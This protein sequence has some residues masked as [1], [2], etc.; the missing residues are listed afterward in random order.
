MLLL[1]L[2][3]LFRLGSASATV[4]PVY[5]TPDSSEVLAALTAVSLSYG[6][7]FA[8]A[9]SSGFLNAYTPD[10][11]ILAAGSPALCSARGR[12][13]FYKFAYK[14]GIRNVV[15]HTVALYGLTDEYVTE[16]GDYELFD[17]HQVSLEKG[18]YLVLWKHTDA[19]WRMFRD[20]FNS[21]VSAKK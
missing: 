16:Q 15:F 4:L 3:F 9:D 13:A 18:K 14:A 6:Q 17:E 19:G 12:L 8:Q 2:I 20:S 1:F 11:C 7:A 21:N 10:A 5:C